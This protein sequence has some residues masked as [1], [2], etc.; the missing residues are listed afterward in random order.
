MF[1]KIGLA[2]LL[3]TLILPLVAEEKNKYSYKKAI[4]L[5]ALVPG[6][7][8]V[9][10]H[11][12]TKAGILFASELTV[13]FAY[14]RMNSQ[15]AWAENSYMDLAYSKAG[16]KKNGSKE[17]YSLAASWFSSEE[18]NNYLD[19]KAR[20]YYLLYHND[21]DAYQAYLDANQI[22]EDKAWE[23]DTKG[24]WTKYKQYR[25]DK[26]NY[27]IYANLVASGFILNRL[28]SIL[29]SVITIKRINKKGRLRASLDLR[30]KGIKIKYAYKF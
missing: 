8:E 17:E 6:S 12:Y 3:L 25:I 26:Q 11:K 2:L 5:S 16:I 21:P 27:K 30:K 4:L 20:N 9:Y 28:F 7:G 29:D 10:L 1:K 23:W 19:M 15:T 13:L 24:N 18:Y 22:S 14:L